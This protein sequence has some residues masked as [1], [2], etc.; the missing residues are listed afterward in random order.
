MAS[1]SGRPPRDQGA[2]VDDHL[3][4][5][6]GQ[7]LARQGARIRDADLD[8]H[9]LHD[10]GEVAGGVFRRQQGE[11]GAGGRREA[12][13]DPLDRLI[14]IGIQD[15]LHLLARLHVLQLGLLEVGLDP[16]LAQ[17]HQAGH[18]HT[19]LDVEPFPQ[20]ALADDAVSRGS[21]L[22]VAELQPG[23]FKL[24]L[25]QCQPGLV[26][27]GFGIQ[28]QQPLAGGLQGGLG[29]QCLGLVDLQA[30]AHLVQA[31]LGAV[32]TLIELA[33]PAHLLLGPDL[34]GIGRADLGLGLADE[35]QLLDTGGGEVIRRRLVEVQIGLGL[36]HLG[37]VF[38]VV[39]PGD[40]LAGL[41][42]LVVGHQYLADVAGELGTDAGHLALQVGVVG[43]LEV[44][45]MQI[46]VTGKQ[47]AEQ[48]Q[49]QGGQQ[50]DLLVLTHDIGF[51][52]LWRAG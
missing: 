3:G 16:H 4:G 12:V 30:G 2:G 14:R 7:Q 34:F 28:H 1:I 6:A 43:A 46:P 44:A 23:L 17:G 10:F 5:E 41:H 36:R 31:V 20:A 51:P 24:G 29:L 49:H 37:P 50:G 21:Q 26:L 8:R 38:A 15:H 19:G 45:A 11:L 33:D 13:D 25:A 9:S 48:G 42:R 18:L 22:G 35:A 39:E 27:L 32:V 47:Q 52:E 40:E